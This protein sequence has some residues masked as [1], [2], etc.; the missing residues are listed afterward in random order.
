MIKEKISLKEIF[1]LTTTN[2]KNLC[3]VKRCTNT[4]S[5]SH[6]TGLCPKHQKIYNEEQ[7]KTNDSKYKIYNHEGNEV[8]SLAVEDYKLKTYYEMMSKEFKTGQEQ[9][10]N[11]KE[12]DLNV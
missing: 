10:Y 1:E 8:C 9:F 6:K 4:K 11:L 7:L 5:P 12:V 3:I 2:K